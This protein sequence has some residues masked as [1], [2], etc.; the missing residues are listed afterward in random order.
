MELSGFFKLKSSFITNLGPLLT[1]SYAFFWKYLMRI[2]MVGNS[3]IISHFMRA[4]I[5]VVGSGF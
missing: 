3:V 4:E 1:P 5:L 2:E